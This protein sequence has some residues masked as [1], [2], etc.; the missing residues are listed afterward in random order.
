MLHPTN[1]IWSKVNEGLLESV[2]VFVQGVFLRPSIIP[3]VLEDCV[4]FDPNDLLDIFSHVE[5][6]QCQV[7]LV[8]ILGPF[9]TSN[10]SPCISTLVLSLKQPPYNIVVWA[11]KVS[12]MSPP[13]GQV[14]IKG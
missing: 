5:V 13:P 12:I 14:I 8:S 3:A 10:G 9:K 4:S 2:D 7:G 6:G 11:P 1:I